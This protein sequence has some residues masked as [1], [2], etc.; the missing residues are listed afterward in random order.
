MLVLSWMMAVQS[1]LA[2]ASADNRVVSCMW[3]ETAPDERRAIAE[4]LMRE[5]ADTAG[6]EARFL[7][8]QRTC[9]A[10][11][12]ATPSEMEAG[13]W[14]F[15][16]LVQIEVLRPRLDGA[17]VPSETL[18]AWYDRQGGEF[19]A[20]LHFDPET[21]E[22]ADAGISLFETL[23]AQGVGLPLRTEQRTLIARFLSAKILIARARQGLP[24]PVQSGQHP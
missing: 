21:P 2:P 12:R 20:N 23:E 10:R 14:E 18:E 4:T 11:L 17:G 16:G 8:F 19:Q 7:E 13:L 5:R 24:I 9:H 15:V 1:A 6:L 3:A 22:L